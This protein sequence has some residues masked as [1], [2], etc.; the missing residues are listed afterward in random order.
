MLWRKSMHHFAFL[1]VQPGKL[2]ISTAS[3]GAVYT[4]I[5]VDTRPA[6]QMENWGTKYSIGRPHQP[7]EVA[8]TYV[9]LASR[10]ATLYCMCIQIESSPYDTDC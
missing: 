3:P 9:F 5:Q 7:S 1:R 8:P 4:P 2:T 10:E 6:Q